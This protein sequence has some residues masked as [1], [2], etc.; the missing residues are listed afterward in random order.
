MV[1][2]EATSPEAVLIGSHGS[3]RVRMRND[4][5][6]TTIVQNVSLR[7]TGR[8]TGSDV[9]PKGRKG[10]RMRHRK[11]RFPALFSGVLTGNDVTCRAKQ[12]NRKKIEK[13]REKSTRKCIV[14]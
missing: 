4:T 5:F 11:L 1:L 14:L 13:V 10:A 7:M 3:D 8:A 2:P 12:M 6:Y 9:T